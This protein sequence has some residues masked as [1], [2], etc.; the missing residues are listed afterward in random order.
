MQSPAASLSFIL[1][2]EHFVSAYFSY[3]VPRDLCEEK[4]CETFMSILFPVLIA[5]ETRIHSLS[6]ES[7]IYPHFFQPHRFHRRF[8]SAG[9]TVKQL[10]THNGN[11]RKCAMHG[12][13]NNE[14]ST[15]SGTSH[16][17]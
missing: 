6:W 1:Q 14:N 2:H 13:E 15:N 3:L 16:S 11:L 10:A 5:C 8:L 9:F 7:A 12:T 4:Y 17:C